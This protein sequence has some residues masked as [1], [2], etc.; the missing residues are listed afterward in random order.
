MAKKTPWK[1][2]KKKTKVKVNFAKAQ[3]YRKWLQK[4]IN[5]CKKYLSE[6]K[7]ADFQ[8]KVY[9]PE[10]YVNAKINTYMQKICTLKICIP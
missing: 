2:K 5:V 1:F 6:G 3:K 7:N 9:F 8:N 10:N 4:N